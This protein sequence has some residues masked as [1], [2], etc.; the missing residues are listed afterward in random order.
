VITHEA[1][2]IEITINHET[3]KIHVLFYAGGNVGDT[4]LR[5]DPKTALR[6]GKA[7]VSTARMVLDHAK[8]AGTPFRLIKGGKR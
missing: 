5:L 6:V 8:P 7:L 2:R 1:S 4:E 3:G